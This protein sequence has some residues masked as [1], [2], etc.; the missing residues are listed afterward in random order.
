MLAT[1]FR[2]EVVCHTKYSEALPDRAERVWNHQE[3]SRIIEE[4]PRDILDLQK[5]QIFWIWE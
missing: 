5:L 3:C 4:D 1:G 2:P